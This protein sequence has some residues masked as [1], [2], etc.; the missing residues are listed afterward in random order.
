MYCYCFSQS[1]IQFSD[2]ELPA[3][4][5]ISD[6]FFAEERTSENG[7]DI[8]RKEKTVRKSKKRKIKREDNMLTV[9]DRKKE[10]Q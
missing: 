7:N 5:D 3:D 2:D 6:P 10:V 1:E 9:E 8:S 4:V